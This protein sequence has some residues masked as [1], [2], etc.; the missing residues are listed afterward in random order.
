[1]VLFYYPKQE[2]LNVEKCVHGFTQV[3]Q[4]I[5][6]VCRE[7]FTDND[8]FSYFKKNNINTWIQEV[9]FTESQGDI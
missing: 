5:F 8:H 2:E 9:F 1:M 4:G 3:M 7:S 6:N